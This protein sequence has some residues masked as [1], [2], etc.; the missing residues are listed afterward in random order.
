MMFHKAYPMHFY[1][2]HSAPLGMQC[3][4]VLYG[5]RNRVLWQQDVY[6]KARCH[7]TCQAES[8]LLYCG[9]NVVS[10]MFVQGSLRVQGTSR[11]MHLQHNHMLQ[12]SLTAA[13]H[14][15]LPHAAHIVVAAAAAAGSNGELRQAVCRTSGS[16]GNVGI[17]TLFFLLAVAGRELALHSVRAV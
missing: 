7:A 11:L 12:T 8:W 10:G 1:I 5:L 3:T 4:N 9:L 17:G 13:E 14:A 2:D 6:Q 16:C 15:W